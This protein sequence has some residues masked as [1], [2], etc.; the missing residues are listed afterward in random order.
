MDIAVHH[1]YS[2]LTETRHILGG[3][4]AGIMK[5]NGI[6][7][8]RRAQSDTSAPFEICAPSFDVVTLLQTGTSVRDSLIDEYVWYE[9]KCIVLRTKV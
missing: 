2:I 6:D 4:E 5:N 1:D 7:L 8:E 3:T 9:M